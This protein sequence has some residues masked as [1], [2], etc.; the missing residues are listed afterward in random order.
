MKSLIFAGLAVTLLTA[1][2]ATV[3]HEATPSDYIVRKGEVFKI[4]LK[5]NPTTGYHW[6]IVHRDERELTDSVADIF[7]PDSKPKDG[8][9]G[10]G[11]MQTFKFKGVNKG[12]DTLKFEYVRPWEVGAEPCQTASYI[13]EVR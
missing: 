12:I 2:Q 7:T 6:V 5:S 13:I 1:C 3:K 11:G 10:G 8:F 9:V 4:D